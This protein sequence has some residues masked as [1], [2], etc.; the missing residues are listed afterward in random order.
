MFARPM[1]L[2]VMY[3][4]VVKTASLRFFGVSIKDKPV[5][6][7]KLARDY[8]HLR[9]CLDCFKLSWLQ[10]S[11]MEKFIEHQFNLCPVSFYNPLA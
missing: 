9:T 3:Y 6:H 11:R 7:F 8:T 10:F 1:H 2:L 5:F 4:D